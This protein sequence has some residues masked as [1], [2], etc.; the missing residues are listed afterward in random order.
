VIC[1]IRARLLLREINPDR[2][3]N[4]NCPGYNQSTEDIFHFAPCP[5]RKFHPAQIRIVIQNQRIIESDVYNLA[6]A[7]NVRR[8]LV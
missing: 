3:R 8:R 7:R 2:D 1:A 5:F 4:E 6:R